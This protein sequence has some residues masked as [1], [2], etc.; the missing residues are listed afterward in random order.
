MDRVGSAVNSSSRTPC[1]AR[2]RTSAPPRAQ[3]SRTRARVLAVLHAAVTASAAS[4]EPS[5]HTGVANRYSGIQSAA[6][7]PYARR[8]SASGTHSTPV[9]RR[10]GPGLARTSPAH[11]AQTRTSAHPAYPSSSPTFANSAVS[12]ACWALATAV[13]GTHRPNVARRHSRKPP[14]PA[15]KTAQ[16][17]RTSRTAARRRSSSAVTGYAAASTAPSGRVSAASRASPAAPHARRVP[18]PRTSSS[19]RA[20]AARPY[21]EFSSPEK[22]H[23][24]YEYEAARSPP[25]PST[26]SQARSGSATRAMPPTQARVPATQARARAFG[27]S[28]RSLTPDQAPWSNRPSTRPTSSRA[29][30]AGL[31]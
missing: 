6:S 26:T 24:T 25:V 5:T 14:Y 1:P 11:P 7:A 8:Q 23:T 28:A 18:P 10:T 31:E 20:A 15:A 12:G 2:E 3:P 13:F 4:A 17:T 16:W 9:T 30:Q 22:H 29:S 27:K 19:A 21:R